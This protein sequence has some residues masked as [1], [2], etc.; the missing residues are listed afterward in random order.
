MKDDESW[1]YAV[2]TTMCMPGWGRLD[3]AWSESE[4]VAV[5]FFM[6]SSSSARDNVIFAMCLTFL[7][8]LNC[9]RFRCFFGG[10]SGGKKRSLWLKIV[11][12]PQ[13]F[14][15][16]LLDD[17]TIYYACE[18]VLCKH[19]KDIMNAASILTSIVSMWSVNMNLNTPLPP[20]TLPPGPK[21]CC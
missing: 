2:V 4:H 9:A 10:V 8:V 20:H 1:I 13:V 7:N 14:E 6:I 17:R 5:A 21:F 11:T 3:V 18:Q 19:R 16:C 15:G 12:R